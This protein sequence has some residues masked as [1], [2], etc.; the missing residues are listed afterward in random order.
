MQ[1]EILQLEK[2][3]IAV[4]VEN[5]NLMKEKLNLEVELLRSQVKP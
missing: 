1:M 2:E 3:R 5:M 4:E